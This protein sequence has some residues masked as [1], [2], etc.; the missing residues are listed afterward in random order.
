MLQRGLQQGSSPAPNTRACLHAFVFEEHNGL[1]PP[2]RHP[3][4]LAPIC[5]LGL[6]P[7][8]HPGTDALSESMPALEERCTVCENR[9][10]PAEKGQEGPADIGLPGGVL[11]LLENPWNL[12]HK[13]QVML[14]TLHSL[15]TQSQIAPVKAEPKAQLPS[16]PGHTS[17]PLAPYMALPPVVPAET[18]AADTHPN[19]G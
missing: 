7:P 6:S 5:L 8:A 13:P 4:P 14:Q 11:S 3:V 9:T 12:Y 2:C 16:L 10:G 17:I 15:C 19:T 1:T 18:G